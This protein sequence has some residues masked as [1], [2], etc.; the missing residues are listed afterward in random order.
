MFSQQTIILFFLFSAFSL[1]SVMA[2]NQNNQ[3]RF[4]EKGAIDFNTNPPGSP[5]GSAI[6]T[7]EGSA[8]VADRLTGALL[9]Y[10]D[11]ITVWNASNQPMPNGTGLLGG[12][13]DLKSSTT[14]AVII[15]KPSSPGIFYV[16]TIDEQSS[17]NG[18]RYS[19]VDMSLD[20]GS[21]DII[22]GQKNVFL[23]STSSEKL[24]VVPAAEGCGYWLLT[25]NNPGNTFAAF[26]ITANGISTTPVLSTGGGTQ[27]NGAG[28]IKVNRQ[29]NKLALGNLF[30]ATIE[31][32]DFNNATG[33]VSNPVIWP[34]AYPNALIYGVEFSPDGFKLYISNIEKIIQYDVNQPTPALIAASAYEVS[35]TAGFFYQPASLQLGPDNKIYVAAGTVD[36]INSPDSPGNSCGF[37][38][39][40]IPLQDGGSGYGLPQWIYDDNCSTDIT[41]IKI[42]GDTCNT[43][44]IAF[45]AVGT[46]N[47]PYFFWDFDDPASGTNDTITI[48]GLSPFAFPTHTFSSPGIYNVCVSFQEPGLPVETVCRS[49]SIGLCCN[50]ATIMSS[51]TCLENNIAFSIIT[52]AVINSVIW[53]FGDT[54]SGLNN[55]ANTINPTHIFSEAGTYQVQAIA[56]LDCG[57]DTITKTISVVNCNCNLYVPNAFTPNND[58]TNDQFNPIIA[59]E[60][61]QFDFS[62]FDRWGELIFNTSNPA[63]NWD[64][65]Y[66]SKDC[67]V[68]VYA[69]LLTYTAADGSSKVLFGDVTLLR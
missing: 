13:T 39:N 4:G 57:A 2:Q 16:V 55:T 37:Q 53:N 46:S 25:H 45:Q 52:D 31:L 20:G 32:F 33:V 44:G 6:Q 47:S 62:V 64:G 51:D 27:G 59:C 21:G 14:A 26:K 8:S 36:V 34:F 19:V 60:I 48:T 9:F 18:T 54:A 7:P 3:W 17:G 12:T 30:D 10:T 68:D 40:A 1:H 5:S 65:K 43:D 58:G 24:H 29:F 49:I 11:G 28:H 15:P 69:W 38:K 66:K 22:A 56:N 50:N 67:A 23:F 41:G 42:N 61:S 63:D 35:Q